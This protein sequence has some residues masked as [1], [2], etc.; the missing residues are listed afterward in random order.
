MKKNKIIPF[1]LLFITLTFL[2]LFCIIKYSDIFYF[3]LAVGFTLLG[4]VYLLLTEIQ[5]VI[6]SFLKERADKAELDEKS[7]AEYDETEK[8]AKA[9]YVL[10][11]RILNLLEERILTPEENMENLSSLQSEIVRAIKASIKYDKDNANHLADIVSGSLQNFKNPMTSDNLIQILDKF[12]EL[13][14]ELNNN[15]LTSDAIKEQLQTIIDIAKQIADNKEQSV[16]NNNL[17][18]T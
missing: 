3:P 8:L 4:S 16:S 14:L 17:E 1:S 5:S 2:E 15:K 7:A 10:E 13:K 9:T 11:K 18:I 6:I 12:D